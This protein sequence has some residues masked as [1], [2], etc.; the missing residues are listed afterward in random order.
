MRWPPD[1][2]KWAWPSAFA[3]RTEQIAP[4]IQRLARAMGKCV[5]AE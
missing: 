1:G 4:A 3:I 5:A 2:H